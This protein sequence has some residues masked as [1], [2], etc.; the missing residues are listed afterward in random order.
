M[1]WLPED[2]VAAHAAAL[3]KASGIAL[4]AKQNLSEPGVR[5]DRDTPKTLAVDSDLKP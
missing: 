1:M 5:S 4:R 2:S 3:L